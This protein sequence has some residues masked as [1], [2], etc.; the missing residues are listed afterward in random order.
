MLKA[1]ST[2]PPFFAEPSGSVQTGSVQAEPIQ[3]LQVDFPE[4]RTDFEI[5]RDPFRL[6]HQRTHFVDEVIKRAVDS[7]L[8]AKLT[9]PFAVVAVGGYGRSELFPYSD[10]DLLIV[11]ENESLIADAKEALSEFC[12]VVWDAKL[13]L[14]HS[15]RTV[16]ECCRLQEGN[17]ELHVSLLDLRFLCGSEQVFRSLSEGLSEFYRRS[18]DT[19]TLRLAELARSRHVKHNG[20]AYHL[21]PNVKECPGGIRDIHLIHWLSKLSPRDDAV[22]ESVFELEDAKSFLY[23]LRCFLHFKAGRDNNLL[24]FELQ[25]EGSVF[26]PEHAADPSEWM[27]VYYGHARRIFQYSL[28]ALDF[29]EAHQPSLFGQ[30]RNWRSRLSTSEF[31]ISRDRIFLRNASGTLSAA[32]SILG[33]FSFAA[34]HN[35]GLSWDAQRRIRSHTGEIARLF[36]TGPP[37]WLAWRELFSQPRA[38]LALHQMQE[39]GVLAAAIPEWKHV[40]SL[41]IRDFYHRYTVDEH[42]FVAVGIIDDLLAGKAEPSRFQALMLEDDDPAV[43]RLALLLH[44]LGKGTMPG[45]HVRGSLETGVVIMDRL[46]VPPKSRQTIRFLIE[47]HLHLSLIMNGRDIEDPATARFLTSCV[48]TQEQLRKL[49]L[50]TYADISAVN[51]TAMTPWRLEQLWRVYLMGLEQLTRELI[52]DRIHSTDQSPASA[53]PELSQF[54]EG[55]PTRYLRTHTTEQVEHHFG[56]FGKAQKDGVAVEIESNVDAH[57]LTV[58]ASDT[59]GLFSSLCGALASFGMNIVKAEAFSNDKGWALDTFRFADP[60][61]TLNLNPGEANRLAWTVECVVRGSID[62]GDLLK[63][64]RAVPRP[65]RGARIAPVVRFNNEASDTATLIDFS[66]EDRPGLLYRLASTFSIAGCNID[67]VMIDT[68]AHKAVD[69]F[70]V[71]SGSRKLNETEQKGLE[72]A[73]IQAA[74]V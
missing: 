10:I 16:A 14:S 19:L 8:V 27:R 59:P 51:P 74:E 65:S 68:E 31:T 34:R 42:T 70:Y 71:T 54:L 28:H 15:V 20:T 36:R 26:L 30:F 55:F 49:T 1:V 32:E 50:L 39:T 13:H 7:Y 29:I 67:L 66:G 33:V 44:D 52:T 6:F 24:S 22:L 45:D 17:T 53:A 56:L 41:V 3:D 61:R 5:Y 12:R 63:R 46:G 60:M 18:A 37:G 4:I 11:F 9:G 2:G 43:L 57:L 47:N 40:D 21:E 35:I 73:L 72:A 38:A 48:G 25:D 64:R 23:A 62:V 58:I 69:V